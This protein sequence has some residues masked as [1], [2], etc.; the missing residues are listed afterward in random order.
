MKHKPL[1]I[2]IISLQYFFLNSL[3]CPL[4]L[5]SIVL[6]LTS[7]HNPAKWLRSSELI[8]LA[9]CQDTIVEANQTVGL[10]VA[11]VFILISTKYQL[12]QISNIVLTCVWCWFLWW[13]WKICQRF[14]VTWAA[15]SVGTPS[16]DDPSQPSTWLSPTGRARVWSR[17]HHPVGDRCEEEL[18]AKLKWRLYRYR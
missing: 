18:E 11:V 14:V 12:R 6:T 17:I 4:C 7:T 13:L 10:Y 9:N 16:Q 2:Y 15:G 8:P 3:F 1:N 5:T